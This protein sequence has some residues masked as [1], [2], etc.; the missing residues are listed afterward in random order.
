MSSPATIDRVLGSYDSGEYFARLVNQPA[1]HRLRQTPEVLYHA[2]LNSLEPRFTVVIPTFNHDAIIHDSIAAAAASASQPFDC[3]MIDDGSEDGTV[4]RAKAFFQFRSAPLIAR[5]TIIRNPVP[6]YETAC[7]NLGFALA[8]TEII[9]E[10]QADIQV[11]EPRFDA[12]LLRA[13]STSPKPSAISGRCGHTFRSIG[14]RM[15]LL[16]R[17]VRRRSREFVGLCGRAIETP[18]V[19]NLLK[20]R[21]YRCETVNRG[22]WLILKSDLERHGYLDERHFFQDNDDHDYH[23]RLFEAERRR[24]VYVPISLYAPLAFG[25]NR[26]IR[27]G[28]NR[29]VFNA[30]KLEKR[31][32]PAFHRF[33]ASL[34]PS[35]PPEEIG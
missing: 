1:P 35:S 26:R 28:V 15:G 18:E 4:E 7:D 19:V 22:P 10:I 12:V 2:A 3:I 9:I 34:G 31:G 32:S 11:R 6:V 24:P 8:D 5:A 30:L 13:L 20:G 27:T 23:R 33:L 17:L 16:S 21:I 14:P 29:D 25:A